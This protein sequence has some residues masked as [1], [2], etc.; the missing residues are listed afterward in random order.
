MLSLVHDNINEP[1]GFDEWVQ[2]QPGPNE[3]SYLWNG[4]V[5]SVALHERVVEGLRRGLRRPSRFFAGRTISG[6]TRLV[7]RH[8]GVGFTGHSHR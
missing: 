6:H 2:N 8:R 7:R 4:S 1:L 3:I 5:V